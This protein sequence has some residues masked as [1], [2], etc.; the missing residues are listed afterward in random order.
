MA[1]VKG[2]MMWSLSE[3]LRHRAD[4]KINLEPC[5]QSGI[6]EDPHVI[7]CSQVFLLVVFLRHSAMAKPVPCV[8]EIQ[9]A[10]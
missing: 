3:G 8:V 9:H 10:L 7:Q 1:S 5:L 6:T 2:Q 4:H